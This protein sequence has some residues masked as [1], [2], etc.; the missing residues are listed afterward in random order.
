MLQAL[1]NLFGCLGEDLSPYVSDLVPILIRSTQLYNPGVA[2]TS[3]NQR[4]ENNQL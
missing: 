1:V 4:L 3:L 2:D